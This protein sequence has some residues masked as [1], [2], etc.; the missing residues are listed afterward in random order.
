MRAEGSYGYDLGHRI[1]RREL[2]IAGLPGS[3]FS[4]RWDYVYPDKPGP[5]QPVHAP[6]A[7]NLSVAGAKSGRV[8][9]IEYDDVGRVMSVRA[10]AT[11]DAPGVLSNRRLDRDAAGRLRA[12]HGGPDAFW[13][14]NATNLQEE[15]VYDHAGN[16]ALKVHRP[17]GE[18][19][20]LERATLYLTPFYARPADGR[21]TVQIAYGDLPVATLTPPESE[22]AEP[23]VT[24]LYSDLATGFVTASVLA[25]GEITD[26]G[27]TIIAR[28]EYSP[29]GLDLTSNR[30][31]APQDPSQP[32]PQ[33]F[34]EKELDR[35]TGFSS[36]NARYYNRDLA[37]FLS[38]DPSQYMY[39]FGTPR[40]ASTTRKT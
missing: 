9:S 7:I 20:P 3:V 24:Y 16:R 38:P 4:R 39:L 8:S 35:V 36:F 34:H 29:F 25:A 37:Q 14:E 28:R 21:G 15:Y 6:E 18:Q 33:V 26:A 27:S 32:M 2:E 22:T 40:G 19:E 11:A 5:R 1:N 10:T 12:V 13:V 30:L 17:N 23:M 31:A